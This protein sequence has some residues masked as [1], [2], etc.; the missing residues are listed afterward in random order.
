MTRGGQW[1][2]VVICLLT[3]LV[4]F[5]FSGLR[6]FCFQVFPWK[7]GFMLLLLG[8]FLFD[9]VVRV[10]CCLINQKHYQLTSQS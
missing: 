10:F 1:W 8:V 6:F 5:C 2:S 4:F 9:F 3:W 7:N